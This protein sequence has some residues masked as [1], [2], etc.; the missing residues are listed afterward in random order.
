MT[1]C[2][3]ATKICILQVATGNQVQL[4]ISGQGKEESAMVAKETGLQKELL[5]V[6]ILRRGE[7]HPHHSIHNVCM[8]TH[9]AEVLGVAQSVALLPTHESSSNHWSFVLCTD[10]EYYVGL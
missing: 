7:K 9:L 1:S 4:V 8:D 6:C 2:N 5:E 3:G 10:G